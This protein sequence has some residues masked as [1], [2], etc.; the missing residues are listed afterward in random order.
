MSIKRDNEAHRAAIKN[1]LRRA[2]E[3]LTC[4]EIKAL[5]GC[6]KIKSAGQIV[7]EMGRHGEIKRRMNSEQIYEYANPPASEVTITNFTWPPA[8]NHLPNKELNHGI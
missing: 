4:K 6:K 2:G 7:A 1:A 5:P 3:W 8:P